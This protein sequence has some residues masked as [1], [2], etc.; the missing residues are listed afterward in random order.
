MLAADNLCKQFGPK[1]F[2]NDIFLKEF[3]QNSI[4][5]KIEGQLI[6]VKKLH[7]KEFNCARATEGGSWISGKGVHTYKDLGGCFADFIS[8]FL[9]IQ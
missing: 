6:I 7:C 1:L 5:K 4:L 8:F 3:F 9:N 2:D